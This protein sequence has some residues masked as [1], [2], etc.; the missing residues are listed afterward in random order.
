MKTAA[1]SDLAFAAPRL[2][3]DAIRWTIVLLA[4]ELLLVN[5]PSTVL[6][7]AVPETLALIQALAIDE[8]RCGW[9]RLRLA[10]PITRAEA[11]AARF[12]V[13]ALVAAGAVALTAG[14]NLLVA[15][16]FAAVPTLGE[17][18]ILPTAATGIDTT[19]L[20]LCCCASMSLA[21]V[22]AGIVLPLIAWR[23]STLGAS[24]AMCALSMLSFLLA[25]NARPPL[26]A[27]PALLAAGLLAV[28]AIWFIASAALATRIFSR[29][30]L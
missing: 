14:T 20:A 21:L 16:L 8:E 27:P 30:E 24:L 3:T 28:A 10:L 26:P 1:L 5:S 17:I 7:V 9:N 13:A 18:A 15:A 2:R 4:T 29:R 19:M 23:G 25:I 6:L 12:A 22:A 11:V